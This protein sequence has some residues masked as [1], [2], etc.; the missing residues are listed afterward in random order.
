VTP[1]HEHGG[2]LSAADLLDLWERGHRARPAEKALRLLA[3]LTG[4]RDA[5]AGMTI[6]RR[7]STLLGIRR[8]WF[9]D[10]ITGVAECSDCGESVEVEL[11]LS[12]LALPLGGS[13]TGDIQ[14]AGCEFRYRAPTAGDLAEVAAESADVAREK[15]LR[16]CVLEVRRGDEVLPPTAWPAEA[17]AAVSAEMAAADPAADV[18]LGMTCPDCGTAWQVGLDAGTFL[19]AE[20]EHLAG[21]LLDDIHHLAAVYGWSEAEILAMSA[22]RRAAYVEMCG[23]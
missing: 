4:G 19:W 11:N 9:G 10:R 21:R 7:E 13:P 2:T 20:V 3:A 1:R 6:G 12:D 23:G 17:L 14:V 16:R 22:V 18:T 15:L 8:R 5:A